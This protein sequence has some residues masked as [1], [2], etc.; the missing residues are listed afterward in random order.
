[1]ADTFYKNP[2]GGL[3][4]TQF[5]DK[6]L[7]GGQTYDVS[8][9][10]TATLTTPD[11]STITPANINPNTPSVTVPQT[12]VSNT[13]NAVISNASVAPN[14]YQD[15]IDQQNKT[16]SDTGTE[17]GTARNL[18]TS[19]MERLGNQAGREAQLNQEA[20]LPDRVRQYNQY[21]NDINALTAST[22]KQI[23]DISKGSLGPV[24]AEAAQAKAN[25]IRRD[26][27]YEI[28]M[29]EIARSTAGN[30]ITR[31]QSS[32]K[33]QLDI[34]Y[35]PVKA[36]LETAK[37]L[38]DDLKDTFSK[39][40]QRQFELQYQAKKEE[41]ARKE[42]DK[43]A[44]GDI[45]QKALENGVN[46]PANVAEQMMRDGTKQGALSI[47][48]KNG[49]NLGG[50]D[51]EYKRAQIAKIAQDIVESK[52][53]TGGV[54]SPSLINDP[55]LS[56]A[57]KNSALLTALLS[58]SKVGTGTRTQIANVI[59][60]INAASDLANTRPT[61]EFKG[62]SPLNTLLDI[63]IPFTDIGLP[64][65]NILRQKEGA[66]NTGYLD[67]INLKVQQW[68]S[69]ASLTKQ[70]TD[71]VNK[72]TPNPSDTDRMVRTKLNN[73]VNFMLTQA[74][75][76]LQSEGVNYKPEK[77]NLF[78]TYDLLQKASPEQIKQLKEAGLIN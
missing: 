8:G 56:A 62:V 61:G 24:S 2:T 25:E 30:D 69:G 47:L 64:G 67:A 28:T 65:R 44:V 6:S 4:N 21:T 72:F 57:N 14:P 19:L 66:E 77:V 40:E 45:I 60:V 51:A 46:L 38:Y 13:P 18:V 59:G 52:S 78:E 10:K 63:K 11:T 74:G 35:G 50:L 73:L 29:K 31:L 76:Q 43:T 3:V 27:A 53:K 9:N 68:A 49:I 26:N 71:Q 7:Q 32:I 34:E 42:A 17:K 54:V 20:G 12:P 41:V 37:F 70:Q 15:L 58:S 22:E 5:A 1:M 16:V 48:T 75:S 39:A 23:Q 36:Q 33:N 55:N